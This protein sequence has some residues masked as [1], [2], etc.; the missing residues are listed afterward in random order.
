M[1]QTKNLL[2]QAGNLPLSVIIVGIGQAD[3]GNMEV[4]DGDSGL[5]DE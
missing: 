1:Q 3:F 5:S 4:L 2:V